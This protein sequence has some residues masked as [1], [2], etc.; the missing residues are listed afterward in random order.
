MSTFEVRRRD[1]LARYGLYTTGDVTIETPAVIDPITVFPDL[2]SRPFSNIPLQADEAFVKEWFEQ[3]GEQPIPVHPVLSEGIS[4]G[5]AAIISCWHTALTNPRTYTEW[6]EQFI[7]SLPPDAARYA[8]ASALPSNAAMLVATGFDLFDTIA[9]DLRAAQGLFCTTEGVYPGSWINEGVCSCPGCQSGDLRE[10]NRQALASEIK[11]AA[12]LLKRGELRELIESRCRSDAALVGILRHLDAK[13][14][15]ME[16]NSPIARTSPFKAYT[17]ESMNRVEI[18]RFEE[19]VKSRF[20]QDRW[21]TCV[22]LPCAARKPYSFSQS[23]KKFQEAVAGRAHEVIV[24]SPLGVVPREL[25]LI[26]PAAHYD[27]PVTGYW[28]REEMHI[29]TRYLA[30]YLRCHPYRRVI[31]HLEGGARDVARAAAAEAGI[32]LEESCIDGRP[33]SRESLNQLYDALAGERKR[34]PDIVG[35]TI[36]WQFGITIDTKGMIIKGKGPEKKVYRG[37]QQLFSFDPNTGLL[38]PTFEGWDLLPGCYRVGIE[39]FVPQGDILAP[40]V[41][42]A[43]PAIREGDEV[44]VTGEG[45]RA[46]GRAMMS[47]DEMSRSSR[48]VAVKVRKVKRS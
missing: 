12:A 20:S 33:T 11:L 6:V 2:A 29:L 27:V 8:P 46:T 43:D 36:Q 45:V 37:R 41:A 23:H 22:L 13:K 16:L 30:E 14:A 1:G 19:R 28:D 35:G 7:S 17:A 40:G 38:R 48:G 5:D 9:V 31:S 32:Q 26:Y 47:A 42:E 34:S 15:F 3:A 24:T 21:D 4:S 39:G 25:E 18:D 10:H 44:L